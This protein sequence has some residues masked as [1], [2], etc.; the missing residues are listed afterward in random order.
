LARKDHGEKMMKYKRNFAA[1]LIL[2]FFCST[3]LSF[4]AAGCLKR[5]DPINK[6]CRTLGYDS[7]WAGKGRQ[8]FDQKCKVCHTR[9]NTEKA[10]FLY[11]ESKPPRGWTRVFFTKYPQCAKNGAWKV[12]LDESQLINDYLYRYGADTYDP[13]VAA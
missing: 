6:S 7:F 5:Y 9:K 4:A 8:L 12:S 1:I 11:A 2:L 10:P 13:N 3:S